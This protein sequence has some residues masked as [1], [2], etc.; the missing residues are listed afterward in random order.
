MELLNGE[1]LADRLA[2]GPLPTSAAVEYAIQIASALNT[3]HRAGIVH[4][5][6]KPGNIMITPSGAKLLDFGLATARVSAAVPDSPR[7][8]TASAPA[9]TASTMLGTLSYMAPEQLRVSLPTPGAICMRSAAS[10]MKWSPEG[11]HSV[12]GVLPPMTRRAIRMYRLR[13][14][15]RS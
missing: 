15:T 3:A 2:H 9:G 6:L 13:F 7:S 10:C 12:T 8:P 5:D 14:P 4:R 1:T 11:R